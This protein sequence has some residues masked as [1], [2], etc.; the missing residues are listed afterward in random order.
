MSDP[1]HPLAWAVIPAAGRGERMGSRWKPFL[2]LGGRPVLAW[3]L[4]VFQTSGAIAGVVLVVPE[5]FENAAGRLARRHG[6]EKVRAVVRGGPERQDSVRAG[7]ERVPSE[8]SLVVVHDGV[9]PFLTDALLRGVLMA[10]WREGAA[11]AAL[12]VRETVKRVRDGMVEATVDRSDLWAAQTPQA[13]RRE[14][15]WEAH[16]RAWGEGHYDTDEAA[17]V[18][19]LGKPVHVVPG[20]GENLKITTPEDLALARALLRRLGRAVSSRG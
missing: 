5:G 12:P 17:L 8:A 11:I 15:L 1:E 3:T 16:E 14:L 9:R 10:A 2:P 6:F 18:E 4:E 19:R 7:L 13:F 20:L